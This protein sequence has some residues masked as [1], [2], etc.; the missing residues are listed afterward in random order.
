MATIFDRVRDFLGKP[1]PGKEGQE[2]ASPVVGGKPDEPEKAVDVQAE[3]RK[4][5]LDLRRAQRGADEKLR[6][7]VVKMRRELRELRRE[8]EREL[9]KQAEAHAATEDWTY[10]VVPGDTLSGIALKFYGDAS[11]WP[12]IH[13]ANKDI[14]E[15]PNLI[16]PG[17]TFVIPDDDE[18]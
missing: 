4:R 9:A 13:E 6:I 17:Q 1:T 3:L 16:Y 5:D 7:E 11:R 12:E 18:D 15:N 14:I 10:T 2:G 8:Y